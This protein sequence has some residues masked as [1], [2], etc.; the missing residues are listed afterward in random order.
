MDLKRPS[1]TTPRPV[2]TGKSFQT[3]TQTP[4]VTPTMPT[5]EA[6]A[7]DGIDKT[8]ASPTLRTLDALWAGKQYGAIIDTIAAELAP[9]RGADFKGL[10]GN[11]LVAVTSKVYILEERLKA[12]IN[13]LSLV[14]EKPAKLQAL[15]L[16][17]ELAGVSTAIFRAAVVLQ[18]AADPQPVSA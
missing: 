6:K 8:V 12:T 5:T 15:G 18:D 11:A 17:K 10:D 4:T 14:G 3:Q 2:L 1:L 16:A 9:L 13:Q 7:I